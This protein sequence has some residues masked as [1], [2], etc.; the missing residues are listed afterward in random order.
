MGIDCTFRNVDIGRG[1]Y[2]CWK[3]DIK[4]S[5]LSELA[6]RPTV[7][8][9]VVNILD[10]KGKPTWHQNYSEHE[11]KELRVMMGERNFQKEYMNNLLLKV[12]G[13]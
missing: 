1:L 8:H 2:N 9:T 7:H 3:Q 12:N 5:V 4:T 10:K 11:V 13:S 6:K